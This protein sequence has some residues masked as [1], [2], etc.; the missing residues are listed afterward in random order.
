MRRHNEVACRSCSTAS[1]QCRVIKG[2]LRH[3]ALDIM[4]FSLY[5]FIIVYCMMCTQVSCNLHRDNEAPLQL[6]GALCTMTIKATLLHFSFQDLQVA[7]ENSRGIM[8][9]V[10]TLAICGRLMRLN[11]RLNQLFFLITD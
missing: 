1:G 4:D 3:N 11:T 7:G 2:L 8:G 6:C 9:C 10:C 5:C